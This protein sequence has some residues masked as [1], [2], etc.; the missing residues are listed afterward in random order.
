MKTVVVKGKVYQIGQPYYV[1]ISGC[2]GYL[3]SA[4]DVS[5][6]LSGDGLLDYYT[7]TEIALIPSAGTITIEPIYEMVKA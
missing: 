2:I 6:C 7:V 5:F 3:V 1:P 4:G